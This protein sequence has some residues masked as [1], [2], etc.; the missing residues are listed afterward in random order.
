M[1]HR[2]LNI[3]SKIKRYEMLVELA[4]N[5]LDKAR[6]NVLLVRQQCE[7]HQMQLDSLLEY[8]SGYLASVYQDKIV[9][10]AQILSIQAF[11]DKVRVAIE[12][13]KDQVKQANESLVNAEAYW[14]EQKAKHQSMETLLKKLRRNQTL[15]LAKQEQKMLDE[16]SSQ[17]FYR[18]QQKH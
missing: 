18:E 10:Q 15:K 4:Q 17:K 12:G 5:D 2:V 11:M 14:I 6:E 16:L 13:Q 3:M 1:L 9:H 8:Q 7:S